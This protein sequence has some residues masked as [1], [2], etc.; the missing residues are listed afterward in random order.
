MYNN[1]FW[2]GNQTAYS[3]GF[4]TKDV[5]AH[6][7][8][9]GVTQYTADLIYAYQSGALNESMSDI[10]GAMV[11]RDDWLMGEETPIGVIRS[12]A[13]PTIYGDPGRVSDRQFYCDYGDNGGVHTNSGVPNH[14]AY[15][16]SMG[17]TYNGRHDRRHRARPDRTHLLPRAGHLFHRRQQFPGRL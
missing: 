13:D 5:V 17:G 2:D 7:W 9:H 15:L 14:A 4:A 3:A 12:L 10:F 11:D 16:A 1:A 6:E 8:T